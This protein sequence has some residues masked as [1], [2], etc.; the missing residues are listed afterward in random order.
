MK[1]AVVIETNDPETAWNALRY[2]NT[3]LGYEDEVTVF[4]MGK[5][6]EVFTISSIKFNVKEQLEI[7]EEFGGQMIGCGVCAENREDTMPLL[8]DAMNCEI[9]SMQNFYVMVKEAD[10]VLTF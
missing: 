6:V 7:F 1:V 2:A 8:K 4:L 3:A 9:G 5:G 10:R